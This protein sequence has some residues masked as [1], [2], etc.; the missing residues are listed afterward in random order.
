M[1]R[2]LFCFSL[3]SFAIAGCSSVSNKLADGDFDYADN[4]EAK[5]L[6]IP[7]DLS[8]PKEHNDFF[9][10][11]DINHQGPIGTQVDVRAPS[12][13]LPIAASSRVESNSGQAKIWF[14]Q[15][16]DDSD[17]QTFIYNSLEEQLSADGVVIDLIDEENKIYE[18]QW[19]NKEKVSG[20]W[21]FEEVESTESFRFRYQ[22]ESKPHGRSVA[23]IVS[24]VDYMKTDQSGATKS[25]NLL[26]KQ[27]AEMAML[28]EVV[29]QV[30]YNYRK[31][32]QENRLLRAN[33]KLVTIG[34]SALEEP[35]YIV[36]MEIESLWPNMPIF[37]E[38]HGFS[39]ADLDESKKIY[40]VDFIKPDVSLWDKIWGDEVPVIEVDD[41]RYQF[42]LASIGEKG[43][44]TSVTIFNAQGDV[45]PAETLE[46]IFP[47]MEAGLSFRQA[48]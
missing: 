48:Y 47:V 39:V 9:I 33:Q 32:Q 21:L 37:F 38:D 27:R 25:M 4:S 29:A 28:N 45:L 1:N 15:V 34:E 26:E 11:N 30:D 17:L 22:L 44:Q 46:R 35:A 3:L 6:A 18:S 8:A 16:L 23:L 20:S 36:E 7:N 24:L 12:L 2:K 31:Q 19:Y 43:E 14:D 13:V 5:K 40:Y 42:V 41:Q 10:S